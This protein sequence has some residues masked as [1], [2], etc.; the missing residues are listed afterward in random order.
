LNRDKKNERLATSPRRLQL[1]RRQERI[2]TGIFLFFI[3][4]QLAHFVHNAWFLYEQATQNPVPASSLPVVKEQRGDTFRLALPALN[5]LIRRIFHIREPALVTAGIDFLTAFSALYLL[6]LLTVDLPPA[7]PN[8]PKDRVLKILFFL[9]ILQFPIA[10]VVPWQRPETMPSTLF[11]AFSLFC[12]AKIENNRLWSLPFLVTVPLQAFIRADVPVVFGAATALVGL[13][14][15]I[16][17]QESKSRSRASLYYI[18]IGSLTAILCAGIQTYLHFLY[19]QAGVDIQVIPN[20]SFH[21]IQILTIVLAPLVFFIIFLIAKRPPLSSLEKVAILSTVL[22]LPMYF[23]FGIVAEARIYV[24][25]LLILSM[26][27]ARVSASFLSEKFDAA[28]TA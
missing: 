26:A 20:L 15:L 25:F 4:L 14:T 28:N 13:Q 9:A 8:Q 5:Q 11:L 17:Q 3:S 6:Y 21:S 12:L 2:L 7:E 27:I 10:W 22:Y 1:N 23:T 24:P 19:P 16:K 18:V